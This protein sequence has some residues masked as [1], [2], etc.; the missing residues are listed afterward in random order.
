MKKVFFLFVIF[1]I[2]ASG[3]Y[4]F[5]DNSFALDHALYKS[6]CDK[7]IRYKVGKIDRRFEL[8]NVELTKDIEDAVAIWGNYEG[9]SLFVYD[10]NATLTVNLVYDERQS[11]NN[12]INK[13]EDQI[14]SGK[15]SL[16]PQ[17]AQYEK[18]AADFKTRVAQLNKDVNYWNSQGGA[19]KDDYE[20]L[21]NER[22]ALQKEAEQLNALAKTLNRNADLYNLKVGQLNQTINSFNEELADKPEEGTYKGAEQRIEIYFNTSKDELVHT[23]AH[24]MGHALGLDHNNNPK[25]IMYP[26]TNKIIS[27]SSDDVK[28]LNTLCMKQDIFNYYMGLYKNR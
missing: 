6:R 2:L 1:L 18:R 3:F 12:Q 4:Y 28:A 11:L 14:N 21:T 20:K 26:K 27:L 15:E 25:G 16:D 19:P 22:E 8:T 17:V 9:K 13:L 5:N 7:P 24:E 23:I 10:T